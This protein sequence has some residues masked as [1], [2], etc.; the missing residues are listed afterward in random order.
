MNNTLKIKSINAASYI[1]AATD[2]EATLGFNEYNTMN[3]FEIDK[4]DETINALDEYRTATRNQSELTVNLIKFN[5]YIRKYKNMA[6]LRG[7]RC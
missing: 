7:G 1:S 5:S 4:N 3:H 6:R 2:Y